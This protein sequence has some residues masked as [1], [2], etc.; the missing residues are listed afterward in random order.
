VGKRPRAGQ[1]NSG[2]G[3]RPQG[4]GL[5]RAKAWDRFSRARGNSRT[6]AGALG[7][8][9]LAG[10]RAGAVDRH[11]RTP[12]KPKLANDKSKIG[13]TEHEN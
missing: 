8:A 2:E 11:G 7:W 12:T 5:R 9:N 13:E 1:R 6:N 10:H 4:E 3:F